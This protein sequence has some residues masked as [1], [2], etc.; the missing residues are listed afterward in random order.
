[1]EE[2]PR[3]QKD[4]RDN[5]K[6][7]LFKKISVNPC[8]IDYKKINLGKVT[9]TNKET[10]EI[11]K[12]DTKYKT[13][14]NIPVLKDNAYNNINKIVKKKILNT[15]NS[16]KEID[17][18]QYGQ[19]Y[20]CLKYMRKTPPKKPQIFDDIYILKSNNTLSKGNESLGIVNKW[21]IPHVFYDHLFYNGKKT[22][23]KCKYNKTS[24]THRN[25]KK[26]ITIIYCSP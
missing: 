5:L 22:I 6:D 26:L 20:K 4:K 17:N 19:N 3:R 14:K 11:S 21:K 10:E 15:K 13:T 1:M 23:N 7:L 18:E 16:I 12:N 8:H 24:I 2:F 25:K 9:D